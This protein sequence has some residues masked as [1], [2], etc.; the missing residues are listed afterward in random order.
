LAEEGQNKWPSLLKAS[1]GQEALT[2]N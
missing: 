2:A 1:L